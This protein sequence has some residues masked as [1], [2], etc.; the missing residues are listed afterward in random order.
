MIKYNFYNKFKNDNPFSEDEK[1]FYFKENSLDLSII[2]PVYNTKKYVKECIDSVLN[3]KTNYKYEIIIVNDGSTDGS[4]EYLKTIYG[5]NKSIT[6]LNKINGGLSSARNHGLKYSKGKYVSFIDSDDYVSQNYVELLLT[7]AIEKH[8][9]IVKCGYYEFN[10]TNGKIIKKVKYYNRTMNYSDEYL[11]RVKGHGCMC[12]LK[13]ELF[14]NIRFPIN[15]LYEDMIIRLLIYPLCNKINTISSILYFYRVNN[16]SLSRSISNKT[17]FKSL[18]QFFLLKDIINMRKKLEFKDDELFKRFILSEL[19]TNMF[20]RIRHL[21]KETIYDVFL[22]SCELIENIDFNIKK[23][24]IKEK[25]KVY[26]LKN[27]KFTIWKLISIY[28]L[29]LIKVR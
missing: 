21:D 7:E 16:A 27:K 8:C 17:N 29:I 28:E 25:I 4:L 2:V 19:T 10:N 24:N 18:S 13:R 15:Y 6:I 5:K 20:L 23:S 22:A 12:V 11:M 14:K 3:Q 1:G 9:D 26:C